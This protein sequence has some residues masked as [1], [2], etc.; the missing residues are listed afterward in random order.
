MMRIALGLLALGGCIGDT[1]G[2]FAG[3]SL[4]PTVSVPYGSFTAVG[5]KQHYRGSVDS[6]D[7]YVPVDVYKATSSDPMIATAKVI[8]GEL[9]VTGVSAG[10][11]DIEA[12]SVN[13]D[14]AFPRFGVTAIDHIEVSP[15]V[16]PANTPFVTIE[17]RDH[18]NHLAV[19]DTLTVTGELA[20]GD[21]WDQLAIGSTP[22]GTY[23]FTVHAGGADWPLT[24]VVE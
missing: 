6:C 19:D 11:T 14:E 18:D 3:L 9:E 15:A 23:A 20:K 1:C 22:P 4:D 17:P 2:T 7:G 13:N 12:F 16:V 24:V 21:A 8:N 10:V 5:G